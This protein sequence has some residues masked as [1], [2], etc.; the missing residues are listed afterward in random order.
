MLYA[1]ALKLK[2]WRETRRMAV[3]SFGVTEGSADNRVNK[4]YIKYFLALLLFELNVIVTSC[5][6]CVN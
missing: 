2:P 1:D 4:S 3:V 6:Q 5:I